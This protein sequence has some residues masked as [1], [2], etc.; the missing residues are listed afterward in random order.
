M[1]RI[2]IINRPIAIE[3]SEF[4]VS[5]HRMNTSTFIKLIYNVSF[6]IVMNECDHNLSQSKYIASASEFLFICFP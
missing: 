1:E 3:S 2:K 6:S 4:V 5:F